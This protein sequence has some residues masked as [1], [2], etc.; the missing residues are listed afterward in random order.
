MQNLEIEFK[1]LLTEIEYHRLIQTY[2]VEN[3]NI[4]TNYYFDTS[5][6]RLKTLHLGLRIRFYENRTEMTLKVPE[7]NGHLEYNVPL[8]L[9]R[10]NY[11]PKID[12]FANSEIS[13]RL[14]IED[15]KTNQLSC[16]AQLTTKRAEFEI[17]EGL[18]ALD[19]SWY[20][21]GHDFEVELEVENFQK[22]KLAF[23]SLL[24][25]NQINFKPAKNKI[26]RAS[27]K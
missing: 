25:K 4:Q 21:T 23:Q 24:N 1:S 2:K 6:Q 11:N 19:E 7:N 20:G 22:G 10:D 3:F 15:I 9:T 17:P 14:A 5:D 26:E 18:L 13:Q 8:K 12:Y 27:G 16:F